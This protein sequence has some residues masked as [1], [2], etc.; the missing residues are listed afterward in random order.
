MGYRVDVLTEH[1]DPASPRVEETDGVRVTRVRTTGRRGPATYLLLAAGMLRFLLAN[2]RRHEFAVVR[3][4]TFP[5]LLVGALKALH[6]L[7]YP[8]LVTAETGGEADDVIAL[9][10][11]P[12]SGF[13]RRVLS[14]HDVLNGI[15]ADNLRHYRELGFP[16]AKLTRIYNGVDTSGYATAAFPDAVRTFGFLGRLHREKGVHELMEAFAALHA[17]RPEARLVIAGSG[18]EDAAL[19]R[20]AAE[21]GLG[22]AVE[23][24]GR[25]PYEELG[26]FFERIDCL[27]LPSYSEGLP[28]SVLEAAAHKRVLIATDVS[29]LREL[30]GDD[31]FICAKRDA[32]DLSAKMEA[33]MD[34]A[35]VAELS[36]DRTIGTLSVS[37][38]AREIAERMQ[39]A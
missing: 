17:R 4:L 20:F 1:A 39:R 23:F 36:Y 19:R 30:F 29:D 18:D 12:L 5:A 34:P 33:V 3:T 10:G 11:Y 15:C 13:L 38:I 24:A 37:H 28:L 7:P 6:L 22:D 21:H 35:A 31:I 27:V 14:H 32:A 25:I 26:A 8:T 9:S 16:E 2:R